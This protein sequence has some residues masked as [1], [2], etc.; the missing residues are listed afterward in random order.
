MLSSTRIP[1]PR[2]EPFPPTSSPS[3]W[4]SSCS[5]ARRSGIRGIDPVSGRA[6]T[7]GPFP[8]GCSAGRGWPPARR[9]MR[10]LSACLASRTGDRRPGRSSGR[11]RGPRPASTGLAPSAMKKLAAVWAK[12]MRGD[13]GEADLDHGGIQVAS[14]PLVRTQRVAPS[15]AAS[16]DARGSAQ[17]TRCST[18]ERSRSRAKSAMGTARKRRAVVGSSKPRCRQL[19]PNRRLAPMACWRRGGCR[20]PSSRADHPERRRSITLA[21]C[22]SVRVMTPRR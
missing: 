18:G 9:L 11:A 19:A 12:I 14:A 22:P 5:S 2:E 13:R 6:R 10:T 1:E 20:R 4:R 3:R 15:G 17:P 21:A 7:E 16:S 8:R